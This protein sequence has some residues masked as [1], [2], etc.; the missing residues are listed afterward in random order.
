MRLVPRAGKKT[1]GKE[2][3]R[4]QKPERRF[5]GEV[6][7]KSTET[8]IG[9]AKVRAWSLI[10]LKSWAWAPVL[11]SPHRQ[12]FLKVAEGTKR[13]SDPHSPTKSIIRVVT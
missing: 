3:A 5:L 2:R 9:N 1:A 4:A 13:A 12:E 8:G 6:G 7:T 10:V 11:R